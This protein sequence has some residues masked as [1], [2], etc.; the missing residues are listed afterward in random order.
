MVGP[1]KVALSSKSLALPE[2]GRLAELVWSL[3]LTG[4]ASFHAAVLA[5]KLD[6]HADE[7]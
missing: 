6:D 4:R 7:L 2:S 3:A 5:N 1:P